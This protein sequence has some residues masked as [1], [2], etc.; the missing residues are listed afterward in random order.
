VGEEI[1]LQNLNGLQSQYTSLKNSARELAQ[2]TRAVFGDINKSMEKVKLLHREATDGAK[3]CLLDYTMERTIAAE[4][5][6]EGL[7]ELV[8]EISEDGA[9]GT[10]VY[11]GV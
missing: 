5:E 9:A 7:I 3:R 4:T 2:E 10:K 11:Y 8:G 6:C 1:I